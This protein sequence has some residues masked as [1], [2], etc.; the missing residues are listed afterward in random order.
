MAASGIS[1]RMTSPSA[2]CTCVQI[3]QDFL[4]S[5]AI[6]TS[7][8]HTSAIRFDGQPISQWTAMSNWGFSYSAFSV[9]HGMHYITVT[10]DGANF[11]AN[12][13]GHSQIDSSSSAY[14]MLVGFKGTE[15]IISIIIKNF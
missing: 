13:M 10:T 8:A 7:T 11:T 15:R 14:A 3:R 1:D 4:N 12:A 5:V 9:T 6:I 2:P